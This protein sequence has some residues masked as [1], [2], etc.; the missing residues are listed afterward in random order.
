M[1][2]V[3]ALVLAA[4]GRSA[5]D[6][7][8]DA[9]DPLGVRITVDSNLAEAHPGA[10]LILRTV[11]IEDG[12]GRIVHTQRLSDRPGNVKIDVEGISAF[13]V[14]INGSEV[15]TVPK[16]FWE[17]RS[18]GSVRLKIL[19][20]GIAMGRSV[21]ARGQSRTCRGTGE[22]MTCWSNETWY[23][24]ELISIDG[25]RTVPVT[26]LSHRATVWSDSLEVSLLSKV[27]GETS[28]LFTT[29][30][31]D[32]GTR[33]EITLQVPSDAIV[34]LRVGDESAEIPPDAWLQVWRFATLTIAPRE[35]SFATTWPTTLQSLGRRS[36]RFLTSAG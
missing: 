27:G 19:P 25:T 32:I 22:Q 7:Q 14:E 30:T 33:A 34:V 18:R 10:E 6:A 11:P 5:S 3:V 29:T 36:E 26:I 21:A 12:K 1:V 8:A 28:I 2:A 15:F 4:C 23:F 13:D 20:G 9:G 16:D 31:A 24:P 17:A 35:V